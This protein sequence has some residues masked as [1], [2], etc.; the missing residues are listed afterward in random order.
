[1]NESDESIDFEV[2]YFFK[3]LNSEKDLLINKL[4]IEIENLKFLNFEK[5]MELKKHKKLYPSEFDGKELV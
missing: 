3:H 2:N 5:Q 4:L 1:M